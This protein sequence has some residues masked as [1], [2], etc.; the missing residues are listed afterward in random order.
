MAKKSVVRKQGATRRTARAPQVKATAVAAAKLPPGGGLPA[1]ASR[2][3]KKAASSPPGSPTVE[4][5]KPATKSSRAAAKRAFVEGL[6]ERGEAAESGVP[7][8]PGM[9]H[10]V[11]GRKRSGTPTVARR[12]FSLR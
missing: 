3:T 8:G 12:R 6:L 10:E 5:S 2:G 1:R 9:T 11:V 7:L 4:P